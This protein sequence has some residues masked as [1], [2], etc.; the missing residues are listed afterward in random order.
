MSDPA[1]LILSFFI[2]LFASL[3]QG[4]TAFGFALVSMPLLLLFMPTVEAVTLNLLLATPLNIFMI[5]DE[6]REIAWREVFLLLPGAAAGAVAGMLFLKTFDGPLFKS[7]VAA[8]FLVMALSMLAGRTWQAG[9]GQIL[10]QTVGFIS[11]VLMGSTSMGGPPVVLYLTGRQLS[12]SSLR[13]TLALFFFVGNLLALGAFV[14]GG[15]LGAGLTLRT[16]IL[17]GALLPG[18]LIGRRL[19]I[20]LSSVAF[21]RLVIVSMAVIAFGEVLLYGFL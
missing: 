1:S 10:R 15:L 21:R 3:V 5:R 19:T 6:R 7:F 20:S 4:A 18:Y 13:G 8:S 14:A 17:A 9:P 12:K 16:L 11:G 2:I